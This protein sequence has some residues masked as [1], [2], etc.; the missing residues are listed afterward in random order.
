MS[1]V[2]SADTAATRNGEVFEES[3]RNS[4]KRRAAVRIAAS[5][6]GA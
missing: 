6:A 2:I 3:D 1:E 4:L 5:T